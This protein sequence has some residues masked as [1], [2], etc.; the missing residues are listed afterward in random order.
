MEKKKKKSHMGNDAQVGKPGNTLN[1]QTHKYTGLQM[2][3]G[4]KD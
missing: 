3:H 4:G 1:F 2:L